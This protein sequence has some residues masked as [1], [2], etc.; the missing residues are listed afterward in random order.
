M[1]TGK[2]SASE[3]KGKRKRAPNF[4]RDE[5]LCMQEVISKGDNI[6]T[7]NC[8]FSNTVTNKMKTQ[9]WECIAR[10]VSNLGFCLRSPQDC[11]NK[12]Q[13]LKRESKEAY[14]EEKIYMRGTGGGPKTDGMTCSQAAVVDMLKDTASFSGITGGLDSDEAGMCLLFNKF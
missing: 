4:S 6:K 3:S 1:D 14:T 5:V 13:N 2:V 7:I 11:S 10:E 9:L 12:W 8:K